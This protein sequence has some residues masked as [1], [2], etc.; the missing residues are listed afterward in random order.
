MATASFRDFVPT[1]RHPRLGD[2][3]FKDYDIYSWVDFGLQAPFVRALWEG[4][5][6][7]YNE[8]FRGITSNG[9][10][11]KDIFEL[12]N[13][14]VPVD[15][16]V[17]AANLL[18][19]EA[20]RAGVTERL[21]Y[22]LDAREW[23]CWMN[24]EFYLAKYGLRFEENPEGV[25]VAALSL[26]KAS[27][28][29]KGYE[30]TL[31]A[32]RV[33]GFLGSL[34][35]AHHL[36]NE[37]SFNFILFGEPSRNEP[38]GWSIW[39]HHLAMS[40]LVLGSQMVVSPV[41]RGCEP[42]SIDSGVFKGAEMFDGEM[43]LATL[44]MKALTDEER[45]NVIVYDTLDHPDMPEGFPHPVDGRILT[46]AYED[47]RIIPYTGGE[48]SKFSKQAQQALL[49][50]IE[51]FIDFLPAGTLIAKMEDVKR[52]IGQTWLTWMGGYSDEDVFHF[53][54]HSPVIICE[55]DHECGMYLTNDKPGRFHVHTVVR[56]PN[57]NDY[58]KELIK[59]WSK[60]Y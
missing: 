28:S 8:P 24:P 3:V 20:E 26:I 15:A 53:R 40:V 54:I 19:E 37:W 22:S 4:W 42:N 55:F 45:E 25:R 6:N 30:D 38:W 33:N 9:E 41:F 60:T 14:A 21:R 11:D 35:G 10:V 34:V 12:R 16:M 51:K 23:R 27:L 13:E 47:N 18:I 29:K 48:V 58:G 2:V 17:D 50:L 49:E 31:T 59:L 1:G 43:T 39:G 52:H 57:G 32:M 36:M 5:Q 56:T 46:G 7:L 44:M